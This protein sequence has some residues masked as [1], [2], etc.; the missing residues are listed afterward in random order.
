MLPQV[1]LDTKKLVNQGLNLLMTKQ[2]LSSS[3]VIATLKLH[4]RVWL[5]KHLHETLYAKTMSSA[6]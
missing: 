5:L 3:K 1:N 6:F 4:K 2:K